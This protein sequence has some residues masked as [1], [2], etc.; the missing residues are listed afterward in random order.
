MKDLLVAYRYAEALFEIARQ[1]HKDEEVE[2]EL[3]AFCTALKKSPEFEMFFKNPQLSLDQRKTF[4]MRIYQGRNHE[5]YTILLNFFMILFK[6]HRFY[7]IHEILV[8]FKKIADEELGQG[9][10][11][12][13]TAVP[14]D[15]QSER[16]LVSRL[17][18]MAGYKITVQ[19]EVDPSLIGGV[20][21]KLKNKVFD[22]SIRHKINL[23]TKELMR[24]KAI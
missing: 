17:E 7:L 24:I 18:K 9:V 4:L 21:V 2:A 1:I 23:L 14:L 12:I 13:R 8:N 3:E 5:I 11:Q 15:T 6:K 10:A 16:V 19:K 20:V 22:G